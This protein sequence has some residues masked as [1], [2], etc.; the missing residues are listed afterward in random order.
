MKGKT[1]RKQGPPDETVFFVSTEGNDTW[2]GKLPAPNRSR[3]NGPFATIGAAQRAARAVKGQASPRTSVR[4][5]IR[6]GHYSLR[7]PLVFNPVDTDPDAPHS[8]TLERKPWYA[9]FTVTY[10]AYTDE[11]PVI[12]G[13]R[14]ITGWKEEPLNGRTVWVANLPAV[15][16]GQWYFRQLWV[17]GTRRQRPRLPRQGFYSVAALTR[18]PPFRPGTQKVGFESG[19]DQFIYRDGD[20]SPDWH[21][22]V[23]VELVTFNYWLD[24]HA[25]VKAIDGSTRLVT[26]DRKT[27]TKLLNDRNIE[28][29]PVRTGADYWVENVFEALENPGEWYLDRPAGRLYY[30]PMPGE[31]LDTI[32][33]I[34]PRLPGLM[35]I[36]GQSEDQ[37][38]MDLHFEGLTFAHTELPIPEGSRSHGAQAASDLPGAIVIGN[39]WDIHFTRCVFAHLGS[40]AMECTQATR[41]I[42][43][44][45]CGITDLGAGGIKIWH[46][47]TRTVVTDCEIGDGGHIYHDGVGILIAKSSGNRI[48]HNH[49]H[50]FDYTGVSVGWIW[51]GYLEGNAYGNIIEYNHIHHIGRG[52]LSDHGA[53][54]ML[55]VSTGTRVRNNI[56][57]DVVSRTYG[58]W[59]IYDDGATSCVLIENNLIYRTKCGG[60]NHGAGYDNV[61]R[62]NIFAFGGPFPLRLD[63]AES[64]C[65]FVFEHNI[66]YFTG[67][68]AWAGS[69]NLKTGKITRN[70]VYFNPGRKTFA[71]G[72]DRSFREWR[73]QGLDEGSLV[74]DPGFVD[75]ANDDY[76]LRPDSSASAI[77]FLPF[78]LSEAGPRD[79]ND[80]SVAALPPCRP[81]N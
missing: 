7:K 24:S 74:A 63:E 49:I 62:N 4:I 71:F 75:P 34:A 73:K 21:N 72:G 9:P 52:R 55:G 23:D 18:D 50:N 13:G 67:P 37:A 43:V 5:S 10:S 40:Y 28:G 33:V 59:G 44:S 11:K 20:L 61:V 3:T 68:K 25:W 27:R 51:G 48:L 31:S 46:G 60:Y 12:S 2:S 15:R 39:A 26:L 36:E 45:R 8:R 41:D 54:Y 77:G 19:D 53:V 38:V 81:P 76:R 70:N 29:D 32:E 78:D 30:I 22:L 17:N 56:I 57:H 66:V 65:S 69:W 16:R 6:G 79:G 47:C 80:C 14:R 64:H 35:R 58:G 42:Y 1:E